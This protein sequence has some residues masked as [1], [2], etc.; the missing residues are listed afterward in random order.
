VALVAGL[1]VCGRAQAEEASGAATQAQAASPAFPPRAISLELMAGYNLPVGDVG[2]GA[3][4]DVTRYLALIGAAG[5]SGPGWHAALSSRLRL[6]LWG[7]LLGDVA[8]GFSYASK[9]KEKG[10]LTE[11]QV[12]EWIF[13]KQWAPQ[14]R[15]DPEIGLSYHPLP[16]LAIR[17]FGGLGISLNS[18][19][20][21]YWDRT[22][23][24]QTDGPCDAAIIPAN[25]QHRDRLFPYVGV[26]LSTAAEPLGDEP[27][28][29]G[30]R[31]NKGRWYGWQIIPGDVAALTL[32]LVGQ[33]YTTPE[34]V[35]FLYLFSGSTAHLLHDRP[36]MAAISTVGR[37]ALAYFGALI[38]GAEG[39][40]PGDDHFDKKGTIIGLAVGMGIAAL[41]DELLLARERS[42]W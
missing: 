1:A 39:A 4:F 24:S 42:E 7:P 30:R 13:S 20:C 14:F 31:E 17:V 26:S 29:W 18:P 40:P 11:G 10:E 8:L 15:F 12:T 2:V 3:A 36:G 32:A 35:G 5:K 23:A 37:L 25:L 16:R 38:G 19:K 6:R 27:Q 9:R 33:Q 34:R 21:D 41:V 28:A 22:G